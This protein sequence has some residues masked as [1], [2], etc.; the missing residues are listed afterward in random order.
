M[1]WI[2]AFLFKKLFGAGTD[3]SLAFESRGY[4]AVCGGPAHFVARDPWLR[5]HLKC[6]ACHSIPRERALMTVLNLRYP[7]WR[8]L[9]LHESS[10]GSPTSNKLARECPQFTCTHYY[11]DIA[12]GAYKD[13]MRSENLER[14]TFADA[15]FDIVVTQDVMEHVLDPAAAYRDI[16]RTLKPGG[17]HIFTTPV[18]KELAKSE[19]RARAN[20]TQIEYLVEPEYH[21]NPI[22]AKGALVTIHYGQDIADLIHG[23][24][25]LSTTVYVIRD[26]ALGIAGEF[27][28]VMVTLK[29]Q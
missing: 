5:D 27:L 24:C 8:T 9:S 16:A 13:G 1:T 19:V 23:W 25:G 6:D 2:G 20:G 28:E 15:S 12:P 14:Q 10:P 17:A 21:G 4:C 18:Y 26:P 7:N 22:D 3:K 29:P 11:P